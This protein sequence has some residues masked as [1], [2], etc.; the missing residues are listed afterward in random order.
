MYSLSPLSLSPLSQFPLKMLHSPKFTTSRNS[1]CSVQI[2]FQIKP[3]SQF[4]SVPRDTEKYKVLVLVDFGDVA[5]A[6]ES[7]IHCINLQSPCPLSPYKLWIWLWLRVCQL[8]HC[9]A[10]EY[11]YTLYMTGEAIHAARFWG[12]STSWIVFRKWIRQGTL[13]ANPA[14]RTV[15]A[16]YVYS[17]RV[18]LL[19]CS[20]QIDYTNIRHPWCK[21][22]HKANNTVEWL[23]TGSFTTKVSSNNKNDGTQH[24]LSPLKS[25]LLSLFS[26][27]TI[28]CMAFGKLVYCATSTSLRMNQKMVR[29]LHIIM[30]KY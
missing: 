21:P 18:W 17:D 28:V 19:S 24:G 2:Q 26:C 1:N 22:Y 25:S 13:P 23:R 5:F 30:Q 9:I 7:I 29:Y 4:E 10:S 27:C 3:K 15:A 20:E 8:P 16:K 11:M 6:V 12:S 14:W